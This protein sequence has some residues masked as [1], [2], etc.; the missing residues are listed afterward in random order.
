MVVDTTPHESPEEGPTSETKSRQKAVP[1][2]ARAVAIL[3]LLGAS[4]TPL[5]VNAIAHRLDI[6]PSTC[7]HILRVLLSE[8]LVRVDQQKRYSLDYGILTL[9]RSVL[10][11]SAFGP[12]IQ[13]RLDQIAGSFPVTAL[14]AR[15][16]NLDHMVVIASSASASSFHIN[17]EIGSRQPSLMSATGRCVAAFGPFDEALVRNRFAQLRWDS[18]P[19]YE[20]WQA[21]VEE[22][23]RS[24]YSIDRGNYMRGV[25]VIAAPVL[26]EDGVMA[27]A[28]VAIGFSDQVEKAGIPSIARAL[29]DA[30][31]TFSM[32]PFD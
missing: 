30:G 28:L 27:H 5:G 1:A 22:A 6:I 14:A 15:I 7:L 32:S 9:A 8:E 18:P 24:G 10:R 19:T 31:E 11:A 2:V 12:R 17:V 4:K 16:L 29:R 21:E 26:D 25:T 20:G 3:R 13:Q 23:R